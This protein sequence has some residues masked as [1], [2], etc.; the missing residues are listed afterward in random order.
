MMFNN[1]IEFSTF[2]QQKATENDVGVLEY[3]THYVTENSIEEE[4]IPELLTPALKAKI[5]EE[6]R[7]QYSMPKKT[8]VEI[9]I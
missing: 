4:T 3:L 8:T 6:A 7:R 5:E 9:D 2:I 1:A